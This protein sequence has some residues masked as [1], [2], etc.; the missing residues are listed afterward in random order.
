MTAELVD[1]SPRPAAAEG[2]AYR[3]QAGEGDLLR[4]ELLDATE[5]LLVAKGS[6]AQVSLREV[7]RTVGV[8]ATSIYLHFADKDELLIAVCQRRFQ[9]FSSMLR[10]ARAQHEQPVAQLRACGTAYVRFGL[11]HPEQYKVLFGGIPLELALERLE[12][13][14]LVG[15]QALEEMASIV[16]AGVTAGDFRPVDPFQTALSLWAM[17]HGLVG[18]ITH[19]LDKPIDT[20]RLVEGSLDLLLVGLQ[21]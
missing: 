12:P 13:D 4:D 3:A 19:G 2:R 21:T 7:A 14:E 6:M 9:A 18:V 20:D 17:V 15:L 11:E 1:P 8:S 16:H 10:A 5:A